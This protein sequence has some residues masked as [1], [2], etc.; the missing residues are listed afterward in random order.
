M[1]HDGHQQRNARKVNM[2]AEMEVS[3]VVLTDAPSKSPLKIQLKSRRP[4]VLSME[5][6]KW[7]FDTYEQICYESNWNLMY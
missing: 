4:S 1:P 7:C 3:M 5:G 6:K 2:E